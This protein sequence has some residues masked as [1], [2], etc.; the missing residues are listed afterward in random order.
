MAKRF[1]KAL[2]SGLL[3]KKPNMMPVTPRGAPPSGP[4]AIIITSDPPTNEEDLTIKELEV[5]NHRLA[6]QAHGQKRELKQLRQQ[7]EERD[8]MHDLT[9]KILV[10]ILRHLSEMETRAGLIA[11]G[12]KTLS[13]VVPLKIDTLDDGI[14]GELEEKCRKIAMKV[15]GDGEREQSKEEKK[16]MDAQHAIDVNEEL[17]KKNA[18]L[19][20][21]L[22][23]SSLKTEKL[24]NEVR[25]L[26]DH[27]VAL[28]Q[29]ANEA[30]REREKAKESS[31]AQQILSRSG[32]LAV[33]G[34]AVSVD[35]HND[36]QAKLTELEKQMSVILKENTS[37]KKDY[38]LQR[39]NSST[40]SELKKQ[41]FVENV[42]KQNA[43]LTDQLKK[44]KSS[45]EAVQREYEHSETARVNEATRF[46]EK[47]EA[48]QDI[49]T[50]K[51]KSLED[52]L[53]TVG[54]ERDVLKVRTNESV[55]E[56]NEGQTQKETEELIKTLRTQLKHY[57]SKHQARKEP[58]TPQKSAQE[59]LSS[60]QNAEEV[61]T[62]LLKELSELQENEAALMSDIDAT[63]QS[64]DDLQD[65]NER[66]LR[67]LKEKEAR[68]LRNLEERVKA[69]QI[70]QNLTE[71]KR[72]MHRE[73]EAKFKM[74]P[75]EQQHYNLLISNEAKVY[76]Q[77]EETT[78]SL[79]KLETEHETERI[80]LLQ[81][82]QL[83]KHER[84]TLAQTQKRLSEMK[85]L[86]TEAQEESLRLNQELTKAT[87]DRAVLSSRLERISTGSTDKVLEA[88]VDDL[89]VKLKCTVCQTRQKNTIL[90]KCY[91]MFCAECVQS[92]LDSRQR[93][94]PQCSTPFGRNDFHRAYLQ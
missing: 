78:K 56:G 87:G 38:Q 2:D 24:E 68:D 54:H 4:P 30:K 20:K 44:I 26:S 15:A 64:F 63:G 25:R 72:L 70:C 49:A 66:L 58:A 19:K 47:L 35:E 21:S 65:Q 5:K 42:V 77:L 16:L 3:K 41:P 39:T 83:L 62:N 23:R 50:K 57:E 12:G 6:V 43:E 36:T 28:V 29:E 86:L 46:R 37:L 74:R 52:E 53:V 51:L 90:L 80:S 60:S 22:N 9:F 69:S 71:E 33:E 79:K 45:F 8:A 32:S 76:S 61:I 1:T 84:A 48:I 73:M 7:V 13:E 93:K 59:L 89:T 85:A 75:S 91:H 11:S 18:R 88:Q 10:S 17:M 81:Q 67:D 55:K 14:V 40:E 27:V 31:Q 34:S 92:R 94:C 82:E